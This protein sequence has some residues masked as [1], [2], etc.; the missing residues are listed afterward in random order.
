M[1]GSSA[2]EGQKQ[3]PP[4]PPTRDWTIDAALAWLNAKVNF[5]RQPNRDL[6]V[7]VLKLDRMRALSAA[8]GD[9][10]L[11]VPAIHVAGSKGKG[12]ITR[13][14]ASIL[15]A[16]GLR[17]GAF[18][19]PHLI[20][21]NERLAIDRAPVSDAD[22]ATAL[23]R[24]SQAEAGLPDAVIDRF[25]TPTYFEAITAAAFDHF[26]RCSC[27]AAVL[28]VGLGGRLD[29][30]NIVHPAACVL[31]SIELE[32][33]EILGDTLPLIARE[34][35]GILKPGVPAICTPNPPEVLE[36]F[37]AQ[38]AEIGAPLRVLGDDLP[39]EHRL[40][41]GHTVV[42]VAIDGRMSSELRCPLPGAH[43]AANAA[44]AVAACVQMLGDRLKDAAITEGL[45]RTPRDG[46]MEL[47]STSPT[48][49]IDGAHTP[50]SLRATLAALPR[51]AGRLVVVFGCAKD[52]DAAGMLA[53]VRHANASVIFTEAGPRSKPAS[54]LA[55]LLGE[56]CEVI[57]DV[58]S[59]L[60]AAKSLAERDGLVLCCGSF[61]IAGAIKAL[62]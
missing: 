46:R 25:G 22:L 5:E 51:H 2:P 61:M 29:S 7:R 20:A 48:V 40:D 19:S 45:A 58:A 18:T 13:M 31:A 57:A 54:E 8:L 43:Q 47:V 6:A 59:A 24:V 42:K 16:A 4:P 3:A 15:T 39:F 33:T 9:P 44:A 26:A 38:A 53:L 36:V 50:A 30:T 21:P 56:P 49:I 27:D 34:K 14:A 23:W 12:S 32:H 37:R 10:H 17:T 41:E 62:A 28:E 52:K 60:A 11:A 1:P 55:T 35:A